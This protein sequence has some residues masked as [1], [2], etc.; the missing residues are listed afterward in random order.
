M[1]LHKQISNFSSSAVSE[2]DTK[3]DSKSKHVSFDLTADKS[4]DVLDTG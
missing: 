1:M 2:D 3:E 4:G